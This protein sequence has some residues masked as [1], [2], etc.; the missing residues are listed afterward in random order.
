M[1]G[2]DRGVGLVSSCGNMRSCNPGFTLP[3]MAPNPSLA[4]LIGLDPS[5]QTANV[6]E[7]WLLFVFCLF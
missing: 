3:V 6:P 5:S 4:G 2:Q 7:K 1:K